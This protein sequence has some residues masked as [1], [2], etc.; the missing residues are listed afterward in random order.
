MNSPWFPRDNDLGRVDQATADHAA[1][2]I[3]GQRRRSLAYQS[4]A[5]LY[6]QLTVH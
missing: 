6:H 2:I 3:N 5:S 1:H 4:P